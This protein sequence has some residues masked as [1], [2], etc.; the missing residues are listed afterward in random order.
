MKRSRCVPSRRAIAIE[1]VS[2]ATFVGFFLIVSLVPFAA[3]QTTFGSIT[4]TVTDPSG[5][6][7][8][9]VQIT[10]TDQANGLVHRAKSG[11][12]GVYTVPDVPVGTYRA[13]AEAQGF[14][15]VERSGVVVFV[16]QSVTLDFTL[17]VGSTTAEITVN[18]APPVIDTQTGTL[19][20]TITGAQAEEMPVA[21]GIRQG[22]GVYAFMMYNPGVGVNDSGNFFANGTRQ[23]DTYFSND[24]I[25]DMQDVDGIGG[26]PSSMNLSNVSE[27]T[28]VT[29]G[30]NAEYR[31]PTN[32]IL[33]SKSGGNQF[34]GSLYYDWNGDDLNARNFFSATVP[35]DIINNWAVSV[36]GPIK[37]NKIFF[38]ADYEGLRSPGRAV[39][40]DTTPLPQWRTGDFSNL[41]S[42]GIILTNPTTGQ[43][44]PNNQIPQS[45]L[46]SS[47]LKAQSIFYPLPNAGA[48][49]LQIGNWQGLQPTY[50]NMDSFDGRGDYDPR[51]S[52]RLFGRYT[53]H[54]VPFEY[55]PNGDLPPLSVNTALRTGGSGVFS[56]THSFSPGLLN[57]FRFGFARDYEYVSPIA[58]GYQLFQQLGIQGIPTGAGI[59]SIPAFNIT[60]VTSTAGSSGHNVGTD[61]QWIDDLSW[62]RGAHS[63]KFGTVIIR[64]RVSSYSQSNVYGSYN[65]TGAYTGLGYADFLLGLPQTTSYNLPQPANYLFGT[66]WALYAQDQWRLSKRL[67]LDYGIRYELPVPYSEKDGLIFT[68]D[69][70][71]QAIV[72]PDAGLNHINPLFP[73]TIPIVSAT[74]AN[75]P[76]PSLQKL[77]A[78]NFYPRAGFAY[79][80]TEDGKTVIRG[81]YGMFGDT[82]YGTLAL[83]KGGGPFAGS[84]SF[85]NSIVDGRPLFTLQN[86]F[87]AQAGLL[88][89]FQNANFWDP[90]VRVPY[91]QQWNLTLQRQIGTVGLTLGYV[92]SHNVGLLYGRNINQ[93]PPSTTPFSISEL[94]NPSFNGINAWTNGA[95]DKYNALQMSATK[96]M[97]QNLTV[98]ASYTWARDLTN[99]ADNDWVFGSPTQNAFNRAPEWGNN[100]FDPTQ[101]FYAS[102]I[103]ALPVGKGQ[104]F[105]TGM[106]GWQNALFGGWRTAYVATLMTGQWFTPSFDGFDPS[107]T[108]NFGGRPDRV[109]GVPLYPSNQNINDW[110]N[111][112]AFAIPGCPP[113]TPVC[114]N[115]ANVGRFGNAAPYQLA[116]PPTKNLDFTLMK[117]FRLAET[118]KLQFQ[119]VFANI[120][121]HPAFANPAADISATSTVGAI[122]S[123]AGNYLQGSSPQR[124]INF[125]LRFQF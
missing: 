49:G 67:T 48:P 40:D 46:N 20:N 69:P 85:F 95:T 106:S 47:A 116:G 18:A 65:F 4:G 13:H 64:D 113:G 84:E 34:H 61:F 56:W 112:S 33:A 59:S 58:N 55:S 29:A 25:V 93:P 122:T 104:H 71:L 124:V 1:K 73:K 108:N 72:V 118:R 17:S 8:P 77:N 111:A 66:T 51:E 76:N 110:F 63:M 10:V 100:P 32:F 6:A 86:P 75:Y 78:H 82:L 99:S 43:P 41:L 45:L 24:G 91:L 109:L 57:E 23:I 79:R 88:A 68:Y 15:P 9:G 54:R 70:A 123:T 117:D 52:D 120:L 27:M 96:T 37:K 42:Q 90:N 22:I 101:R 119:A 92:G 125:A 121:N 62:V 50:F 7:V 107:N 35:F 28:T 87:I 97:G 31:S 36:G 3:G 21:A 81:A 83:S 11:S 19:T 5:A 102:A 26:A 38:F 80:L 44:F 114:T 30:A 14:S 94:P 115:P 103:W 89:A 98:N 74:A 2:L 60:G 53:Y 16:H 105:L 39:I 12:D